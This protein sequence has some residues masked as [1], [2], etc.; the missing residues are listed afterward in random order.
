MAGEA[1][2]T[3][4][5]ADLIATGRDRLCRWLLRP[6]PIIGH[7]VVLGTV[8]GLG[9]TLLEPCG[10]VSAEAHVRDGAISAGAVA[11]WLVLYYV[12]YYY[13]TVPWRARKT[14]RDNAAARSPFTVTWSDESFGQSSLHGTATYRWEDLTHWNRLASAFLIY[15]ARRPCFIVPCRALSDEQVSDLDAT[16]RRVSL[17]QR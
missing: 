4:S 12:V 2:F 7:L 14:F 8:F 1:T 9:Y 10:C 3:L 16:M 5:E 11:A 15:Y 13:A 6:K 17:P